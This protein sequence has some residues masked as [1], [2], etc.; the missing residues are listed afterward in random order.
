MYTH[1]EHN[2]AYIDGCTSKAPAAAPSAGAPG[3]PGFPGPKGP[4]GHRGRPGPRGP[5]GPPGYLGY[6][7][8]GAYGWQGQVPQVQQVQ[9]VQQ[10]MAPYMGSLEERFLE[11]G[12]GKETL[13]MHSDGLT[14]FCEYLGDGITLFWVR[15]MLY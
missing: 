11:F 8:Y 2:D 1:H 3:P 13:Y 14:F 15:E 12:L 9:Q 6:G 4:K 10:M 7:S 5:A